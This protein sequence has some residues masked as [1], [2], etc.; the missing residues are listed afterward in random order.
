MIAKFPIDQFLDTIYEAA[1]DPDRWL[2]VLRYLTVASESASTG[3][4][5]LDERQGFGLMDEYNT[6]EP[7]E[8]F[9]IK[10]DLER[11]NFIDYARRHAPL[12]F[13]N[14][15]AY[16]PKD[17]PNLA[18]INERLRS[19]N[20]ADQLGATINLPTGQVVSITSERWL[21]DGA[22]PDAIGA[23]LDMFRPHLARAA[24]L[25]ANMGMQ[26]ASGTMAALNALSL[27]AAML[28]LNGKV[29][30]TNELMTQASENV[31]PVAWGMLRLTQ[32]GADRELQQIIAEM[33]AGLAP[34]AKSIPVSSG[35]DRQL[36]HV[37]PI[38]GATR[39]LFYEARLLLVITKVGAASL[40]PSK[41]ILMQLY[42]LTE[43][44]ARLAR[45]LASGQNLHDS[46]KLVGISYGTARS[47]LLRIFRKTETNQQSELVAVLKT[48]AQISVMQR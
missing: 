2:V 9:W 41:E 24:L 4:G 29:L 26:R 21:R 6:R 1:F 18:E 19:K 12:D 22:Y 40:V 3:I 43:A 20:I 30:E 27:P 31:R 32:V 10:S 8:G 37:I 36:I 35:A 47:Y 17:Y 15:Q 25:S 23:R 28:S 45:V 13:T 11:R 7:H 5:I 16:F 38:S 39:N 44:E 42:Q 33:R 34:R 14:R 48:T 46:A